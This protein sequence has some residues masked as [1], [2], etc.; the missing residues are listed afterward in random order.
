M[1]GCRFCSIFVSEESSR[2]FS[3]SICLWLIHAYRKGY[4]NRHNYQYKDC[5]SQRFSSLFGRRSL[6]KPLMVLTLLVTSSKSLMEKISD[7]TR[8]KAQPGGAPCREEAIRIRLT[9]PPGWS[10]MPR[11]GYLWGRWSVVRF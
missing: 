4:R 3:S 7:V 6:S 2:C 8:N 9:P 11:R 1:C 10:S 5:S